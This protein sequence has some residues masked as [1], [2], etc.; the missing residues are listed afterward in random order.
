MPDESTRVDLIALERA[1]QDDQDGGYRL[2]S[3]LCEYREKMPDAATGEWDE[4]LLEWVQN[5]PISLWGVAL[6]A[7]ARTGSPSVSEKLAAMLHGP[8]RSTKWREYVAHTLIRRGFSAPELVA[9]VELAAQNMSPMGLPNLAALLVL[10]P[11]RLASAVACIVAAIESGKYDYV[12]ANV[13]PFVYAAAD[14]EPELLVRLVQQS[15]T[16]DHEAGKR[17]ADMVIEYL[18]KPFVQRRFERGV[19]GGVATKLRMLQM[20]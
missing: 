6:E 11:E 4:I 10:V 17:L 12:E 9:E 15:F 7:L 16:Q 2:A 13:P 19:A 14:S 8:G 20:N 1:H 5:E 3:A 18:G